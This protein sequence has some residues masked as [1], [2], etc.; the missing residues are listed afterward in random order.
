MARRNLIWAD[1]KIL[2]KEIG[3]KTYIIT[4]ANSGVGL[5]TTRQLIKQG[6]HVIM[7]C[8]RPNEAEKAAKSF[9]KLKGSYE[10]IQIDLANLQ[11]VHDFVR[12]FLSK[13]NQ[14]HGLI[15][16]AGL[17]TMGR[18][19]T[20]TKDGLEMTIAV[21]YFGHFLLTELLLDVLKK[22]TPSR[23]VLLS[24]VI[25]AGNPK[26]RYTVHLDDLNYKK[27][28]FNNFTAYGEAKVAVN[29]Y[30][31]ELSK[32]FEGTG[33]TTAS[34]HP[35]W[36]RSNFGG[37]GMLMRIM[38]VFMAPIMPFVSDSNYE[39]AQTSLHCVLS[40][41]ATEYSGNF[42]SQS[43]V[44]YRDKQCKNG[45]WPMES[46]NPNARDMCLAKKLVEVSRDIVGL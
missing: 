37:N 39:A 27:R 32:R 20:Y 16:N 38:K 46:P 35:G 44:L 28:K 8:R 23:I 33:I 9:A 26:N 11:S 40:D 30:A 25:H 34:V 2:S 15:G 36:A 43:S 29:L 42:F 1:K 3:G 21:N 13:Y 24:S 7:A 10:I 12:K 31:L 6:G 14:L 45:G 22:S 4:G 19:A 18:E 17:V 41:K 5:E